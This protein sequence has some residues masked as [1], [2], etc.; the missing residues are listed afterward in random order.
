MSK[1]VALEGPLRG[2]VFDVTEL[3][4]IGR[5]ETCAVR[6]EG[7]HISRIHA[8]ME[9]RGDAMFIKDN[10]SR[11]GIFVNG[12]SVKE[13]GL[14]PD[15]QLEI[16][17][18]LL[19]F[20]PT[21]DPATLHRA[22]ATVIESLTDPFVPGPPDERD[23]KVPGVAASL[24]AMENE[25][26]I[27]R[28]LLE[29]LR[30]GISAGRGFVMIVD[31]EGE[32]KP[33]ARKAPAGDEEFFLSNV[34]YHAISQERRSVIASDLGRRQPTLGKPVGILAVPLATKGGFLGLA[35]LDA[36]IPEGETKASFRSADLRF[37]A[38][39]AAFASIRL[40]QIRRIPAAAK[41]G[42]KPLG[43]I[44]LAFERECVI[45]VLRQVKGDLALAAPRL[46]L[47]KAA[48][49]AKLKALE[50]MSTPNPVAAPASPSVASAKEGSPSA[51]SVKAGPA[52]PARPKPPPPPATWN[53]VQ[54]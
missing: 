53:S 31:A 11:N 16:G 40:S 9:K 42:E 29:A 48:F 19:V 20:D 4:S 2:K 17:E 52:P 35:Y 37:A 1:L 13:A 34:L 5:G 50:L 30:L 8:R 32:L 12:Q 44:V 45:E 38:M 41:L 25:K 14:R 15:D 7:R 10:G 54:T 21:R 6:L 51:A 39:L 23:A 33:A 22:A 46:G 3:A 36:R 49:D 18:H 47:D 43:E 24:I 27:A 26:E 28:A